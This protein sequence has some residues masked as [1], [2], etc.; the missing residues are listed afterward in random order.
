MGKTMPKNVQVT[1]DFVRQLT[2]YGLTTAEIL[3]RY[4]DHPH[5]IQTFVWQDYDVA[6]A[7]P[8]LR[9]F[10]QFWQQTLEGPLV[11][12]RVGHSHLIKPAEI[13]LTDREFWLH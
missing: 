10:L 4:P 12:V 13:K 11:S 6:P 9:K 3:Y 5:L 8:V 2:G 1:R 7:F